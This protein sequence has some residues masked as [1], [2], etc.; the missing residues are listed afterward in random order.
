ML[1]NKPIHITYIW[2][3]VPEKGIDIVLACIRRW[4]SEKRN[5]VWHICWD[6]EKIDEFREIEKYEKSEIKIY[7]H[8]DKQRLH[9]V[10]DTTD[11]VLMPSL[12]LE[13]FGLVALES[14]SRGVAVCGFA[15]GW[16]TE[17]IH[18]TLALDSTDPVNSFFTILDSHSFPLVDVSRFSYSHWREQLELLTAWYHRIL[19]VSDYTSLVWGTEQYIDSL[20]ESLRSIGKTVEI[21]G[22]GGR[23]TR[24]IRIWLMLLTPFAFWRGRSLSSKIKKVQPDLIW[25]HSILRYIG[26]HWLYAIADV[27]CSTYITHHDLWLIT[28]FPSRI[29]S[30]SDIASS[31]S[32]WD[33]IGKDMNIFDILAVWVKWVISSWIWSLFRQIDPTHVLP[34]PWMSSHFRKYTQNTPTIFPHTSKE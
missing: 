34:S 1:E 2:R 5:I 18:P 3:L 19:L 25:M 12:F 29:Y 7:G 28:P 22:Y 10:L 24:S 26:P 23:V 32:L 8:I 27:K 11:L 15:R 4:L 6:G 33:W 13:T 21:H 31:P 20:A 9:Q 16:L 30:E 17:F 14:I